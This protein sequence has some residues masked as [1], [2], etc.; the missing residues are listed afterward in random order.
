M[1]L[2]GIV[3][4]VVWR[5]YVATELAGAEASVM[6]IGEWLFAYIPEIVWRMIVVLSKKGLYLALMAAA[7][8]FAVRGLLR[9]R[10]PFDR[11]AIITGAIFLGYNAFLLFVYVSTFGKFDALR[12]ASLWRY[13][14]HL[15]PIGIAFAAYGLAILWARHVEPR[16]GGRPIA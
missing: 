11:L 4:Y 16:L 1:T 15:G 5:Y 6:P 9:F 13:N 2:P 12:A 14:M 10:T 3:I 8:V 7:T